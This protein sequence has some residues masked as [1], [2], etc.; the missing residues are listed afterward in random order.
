[1]SGNTKISNHGKKMMWA[2]HSFFI[3]GALVSIFFVI[4][5]YLA[6]SPAVF[7]IGLYLLLTEWFI[8]IILYSISAILFIC[9]LSLK[10]DSKIFDFHIYLAKLTKKP[11]FK[12]PINYNFDPI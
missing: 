4:Y 1:M 7:N 6:Y 2:T 11:L 12:A 10:I 5:Y 8:Y 9:G 3:F